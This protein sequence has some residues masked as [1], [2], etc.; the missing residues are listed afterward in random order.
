[1][2][3]ELHV[4]YDE[5]A[6]FLEI[7]VG[8]YTDS[9]CRDIAEGVYERIDEQTGEIKGIGILSFKKRTKAETEIDITLPFKMILTA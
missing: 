7:Q 1:M 4:Y 9:Y 2:K 5:E 3:D 6:D 8:P